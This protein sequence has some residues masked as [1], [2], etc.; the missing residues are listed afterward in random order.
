MAEVCRFYVPPVE[1]LVTP[2]RPFFVVEAKK[3]HEVVPAQFW[4]GVPAVPKD[5]YTID[6]GGKVPPAEELRMPMRAIFEEIGAV[7]LTNTGLSDLQDMRPYL[8]NVMEETMEYSGG[9]NQREQ[10]EPF[11]YEVGAPERASLHY[12]HEMAYVGKSTKMLGFCCNAA[13]GGL[14]GATFLSDNMGMTNELLHM[15]LGKKLRE[16]GICYMRNLHDRVA[17]DKTPE[18]KCA[19]YNYW[20]HSFG[21]ED[22]AEAER[23]ANARGLEVTWGV[24]PFGNGRYMKTSFNVSAYEYFPQLD[25]NVIYASIA[26][27]EAWFDTWP[28]VMQL[29]PEDR[30]LK[31]TYGDGTPFTLEDW[32]QWV[33]LHDRYGFP[34]AW[35]VGDIAVVCNYRFAHGRPGFDCGPGEKRQLGVVLGGTFD[36]V[37]QLEGKW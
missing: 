22:P 26:D 10:L 21:T 25:R 11:F 8:Q 27:H 33:D 15:P 29:R 37:G 1:E 12:H 6:C 16:K 20:Q 17:L 14:R 23:K 19:V 34:L 2:E 18:L 28:G 31:M 5:R 13:L 9:A 35:S 3:P 32:Q 7:L 36:R 4:T 24:D 30:S